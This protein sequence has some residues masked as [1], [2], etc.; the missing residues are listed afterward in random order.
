MPSG[1]GRKGGVA[2]QK[3]NRNPPAIETR[4]VRP[5]LDTNEDQQATIAAMSAPSTGHE[6]PDCPVQSQQV[7]STASISPLLNAGS[8][9]LPHSMPITSSLQS[10]QNGG[11]GASSV[12]SVSVINDFR[13]CISTVSASSHGQVVVGANINYSPAQSAELNAKKP[14]ILKFKTNSIKICQ[15][16]RRNY[17][18]H[19]D[20]MGLVVSR[21][22]RRLVSNLLTGTQ[23]LGRESNSHYH[24]HTACLK[25]ADSNFT[26][27]D[28][29]I[30]DEVKINLNNFQ[31]VY[32][33]SCFEASI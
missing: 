25:A 7:F 28:L 19:N 10:M 22:E 15:S 33:I 17:D 32:L 31:K 6:E 29:V 23:F 16:C 14:F 4:S 9:T 8:I 18:G 11:I 30:P 26:G 3:R 1:T 2:K 20:T 5:C 24:L 27:V 12:T 21:L 13:P